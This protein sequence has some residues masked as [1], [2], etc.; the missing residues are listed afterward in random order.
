MVKYVFTKV[1]WAYFELLDMYG[2]A[3]GWNL[4]A[5][6]FIQLVDVYVGAYSPVFPSDSLVTAVRHETYG[7]FR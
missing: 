1:R 7:E 6:I 3:N 4:G 2:R 5:K